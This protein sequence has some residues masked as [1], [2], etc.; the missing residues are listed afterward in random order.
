MV[1]D[2]SHRPVLGYY[3]PLYLFSLRGTHNSLWN[4]ATTCASSSTPGTLLT[5]AQP[6]NQIRFPSSFIRYPAVATVVGREKLLA[7]VRKKARPMNDLPSRHLC[8]GVVRWNWFDLN[9]I[10]E[11]PRPWRFRSI[12]SVQRRAM[13]RLYGNSII[14][15]FMKIFALAIKCRLDG[16]FT[17]ERRMV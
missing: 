11:Y 13:W 3:F 14:V 4:L 10:T 6:D 16:S 1:V 12:R 7:P 17:S 2:I 5:V 15:R 9:S 8:L